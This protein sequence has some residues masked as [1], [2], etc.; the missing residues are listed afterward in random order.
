MQSVTGVI[1][2]ASWRRSL[3]WVPTSGA[4][5]NAAKL[6]DAMF[7]T[8]RELR[9]LGLRVLVLGPVPDLPYPAPECIFRAQSEVDL[10]RCRYTSG[11]VDFMQRDIVTALRSATSQFDNTRF[12][13]LK[14]PFCDVDYC[15]PGRGGHIYYSD[16]NHLS[17]SGAR[18]LRD[19][20]KNEIVWAFADQE[21][22]KPST[23]AMPR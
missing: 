4:V 14:A 16:T 12:I 10:R 23:A 6:R 7:R 21:R 15:W 5:E 13:D 17:V 8:I 3:R 9:G 2:A 22:D 20:Y 19:W 1:L 18:V 11:E